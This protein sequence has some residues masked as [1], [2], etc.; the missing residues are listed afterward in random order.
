MNA[1]PFTAALV[2]FCMALT[3]A[4][5]AD[6]TL[7]KDGVP[8][9]AI[10]LEANAPA[11]VQLGAKELQKY[12][13]EM[14]GAELPIQTEGKNASRK[15]FLLKNSPKLG[16]EEFTLGTKGA[17]V[18]IT[19]GG[20][21]GVLYGCM[22]FLEDTLG[23]RWYTS[24]ITHIP[25]MATIILRRL[26]VHEKPAFEYR[27]PYYTEA[28]N[29]VWAY[30]NRVNGNSQA[31]DNNMGGKVSYGPFVHTFSSLVPPEK[32]FATHPEYFSMVNGKR[33]DGYAQLCL[34][35]PDV[36]KISIEQV[37]QWIR[38]M[39][40]ATIFSVSQNDTG[41]N[42]Q[43]DKC[44]AV[45]KEEG[46]PSGVALRFVNAVA[47]AI[48]QESP[49]VL[50]DTLA[51]QWTEDPPKLVRPHSNVR[52]RLAPISACFAH[53]MDGCTENKKPY[54]NLQAW[55]KITNQLY[56]WHYSTNFANYFQPLPDLDEIAG[57]IPIFKKN[58]VVGLFYEGAYGPLGGG[59]MAELKSYLMAKMMWNT[60]APVKPIITDFL[61]GVYGPAAPYIQQWLDLLHQPARESKVNAHIY[62]PPTAAYLSPATIAEGLK[63]FDQAEQAAR[64]ND[65]AVE[66]VQ[67]ARLALE[68]VQLMQNPANKDLAV[69]VAEKV[70]R[71]GFGQARE[72][73]PIA[74]FLKRIGQ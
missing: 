1:F 74:D 21:R 26:K 67:R 49:N 44:K 15:G 43:C 29:G 38:D 24:R 14:S 63:L 45:E 34:T 48:K 30:H 33:M 68:Y 72:G 28:F 4:V 11:P 61:K 8:I 58:G 70:R 46:A 27:E 23:C 56:I 55:G 32:Y 50:I 35:N 51:Y 16:E 19:G 25:K 54:A 41:Y 62:D 5:S 65:V 12:V 59:E 31:L 64:G 52:V 20:K 66:E 9:G 47:D 17:Q 71:Y 39:P 22:A 57:D 6:L 7:V 18:I 73:E 10:V 53:P 36:L 40:N 42:C 3:P 13:K 69:I 37:R 60:S 2:G